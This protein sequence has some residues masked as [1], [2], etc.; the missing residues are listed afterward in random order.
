[1]KTKILLLAI[2]CLFISNIQAQKSKKKNNAKVVT[3]EVKPELP[4][5]KSLYFKAD[6]KMD[7][8]IDDLMLRMTLDEKIGQ[9][10][11]PSS[12]DFVTGQATNS[13]IGKK[14]EEGKVGGLFNIKGVEKIR[15]IQRVA[16]EKSRLKIPMIFG[17][18]V[19]HGYETNF[20]IPLGLASSWDMNLI[21]QSARI[22]AQEAT[23]DGICWTF[24]PMVDISRDPRWGRVAEGAGEDTYLG[25]QIAKAMV[26]GYQGK[27]LADNNTMMACVKH[28]A[29]Y[30][31]SEAGRDYNTVDM[32]QI[33]MYN[34]YFPPY[35]AAVDAGVGSVMASFNEVDGIPATAN[36]WLQTDVLRNQWGFDG[37]VVTDYTGI[38]EMIDHGLGDL[39]EVSAQ[40]LKAGIDMDMVGEGFLTT[41]KKSL[42]EGKIT[43]EQID[44]AVR[45]VLEAKY[46]LGLFENPYKYCDL[47]RAK[48]EIYSQQHRTIA[49][50]ISSQS[51]VLLKNEKGVLP[52]KNTGT[53]A[54]IGP[55]ADN[56]ENMPG[57][58]SVAAK[59]AQS[60]SLLKGLKETMG[61]KV[62]F[63][64]AKG[65]NI[66]YD[67]EMEKRAAAFGKNTYREERPVEQLL[68]E[69]VET[70]K[71]A[72]VIL[73]A[74][75]ETAEMSGES[76]SRTNI[77]IPQ[78]QK[79][80]LK[81][82]KKTGKP[83]VLILFTGR[84]LV[85]NEENEIA[86]AILNVWF[87]GSEAGYAIS[88]VVFGKVNPSG[89]LP[90]TFPRNV[91]QIP[92]F[93][94]H[95]NTGRPENATDKYDKF[96]SVYMDSPNSAL[97]PFGYGLSYTTFAYSNITLSAIQL[98]GIKT[99]KAS[100]TITNTGKFD[101]A[102]IVQLYIRDVVGSNTRPV[103]ELKGFQ[104]IQLK[105]NESR[106]V[107]FDITPEYL[108]FYN[109]NLTYDWEGG[110]FEIGIGSNS[111]DLKKATV[112][113]SK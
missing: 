61:E 106:T 78:A 60:I 19:I 41:L 111:T 23:A 53:I 88:D 107:T 69:A 43:Y 89:K 25:S 13:D 42:A 9:L 100:I 75:G 98:E 81:E 34:E 46:R 91:G 83:I 12:G 27:S 55:L 112:N 8:F 44:I 110:D 113:W 29:L 101:G 30:G 58:W 57:T 103:K 17:M 99:L 5:G 40:A 97:F 16:V 4:R 109:H 104:K 74:I 84:P 77:S 50:N 67:A 32:S 21:E 28:Y 6:T 76:S 38:N 37:F 94:N 102:E 2:S 26:Y 85:L 82:L 72:D 96:R 93:Y 14:V 71:K 80:L 105:A 66:D 31:A 56:A 54:V 18:D 108:K 63:V 52:L 48:A 51:M 73:L 33:R 49:R 45:R 47:N 3:E 90:M 64:Y 1:M 86:D 79:D 39:Q 10:N 59:H 62:N 36:R 20:P 70:A 7:H 65:S 95:K 35:K 22:A 11:L 15:D 92:L 87:P 68:T 24:S